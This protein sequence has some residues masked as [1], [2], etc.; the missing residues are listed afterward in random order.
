MIKPFLLKLIYFILHL[1]YKKII[2]LNS[3]HKK[4]VFRKLFLS[5][6]GIKANSKEVPERRF[7]PGFVKFVLQHHKKKKK[8]LD[9]SI[10]NIFFL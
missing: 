7:E 3:G 9:Q 8:N 10:K 6:F 5:Y 1:N 2:F 4:V